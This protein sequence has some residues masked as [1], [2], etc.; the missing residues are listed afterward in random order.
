MLKITCQLSLFFV[1][2]LISTFKTFAQ[3]PGDHLLVDDKPLPEWVT[4]MYSENP[5]VTDVEKA[6]E[7]YYQIHPFEKN[8]YTQYFKRWR[9]WAIKYMDQDGYIKLKD[10]SEDLKTQDRLQALKGRSPESNWEFIGPKQTWSMGSSNQV[11]VTW[12]AN[13]YGL[14]IA[15]SNVN[16]VYAGMEGGG[17]YKSIDKGLNWTY[18]TPNLNIGSVRA[19]AVHPT[20][21]NTVYFGAGGFIYKSINGG[22]IWSVSLQSANLW[23]NDLLVNPANPS[24]IYAATN[25]GFK[26]SVN[27]GTSWSNILTGESWTVAIKPDNANI[28]YT[29]MDNGSSS[30]FYKSTD[31]G[32]VFIEKPTGWF[33]PGSGES[34]YGV[35]LTVSQANS[36]IIYALLGGDGT[37][38]NGYIG[39]YKSTNAGE[40]WTN[41]HGTL[42]T[43]YNINTH[44]NLMAHNG[45]DG[46]YQ[47]FYDF[48]IVA[49]PNNAEEVIVGGTSWWKSTNGG[50]LFAPLGSYVGGL[51]WSHPD[52]QWL[53]AQGNDLWICSDGGINYSTD[54]A[55]T[56][57]ARM[58]GISAS[59]FWGFDNGWNEDVLVGGRYHNGN[60]AYY[61]NY[62]EGQFLRMGGAEAATGYVNPG[63]NRRVY[64]SDIGGTIIPSTL[65]GDPEWF[66]VGK[67]PNE[68]YYAAEFSEMEWDPRCFNT[69]FIGNGNKIWKSSNGGIS[70][71]A[72]FTSPDA[73]SSIEHI[74]VSRKNS[75]V[76]YASQRSNDLWD[77]KIWKTTNGGNSWTACTTLPT[78]SGGGRRVMS[79]SADG[80]N[81]N[82]LYVG[83]AY[84]DANEK[85]YKT[86]DGGVSWIN[87]STPL[88]NNVTITDILHQIG[89]NGGIYIGTTNGV[90]YRNNVMSDWDY[91]SNNL[92]LTA[93]TCKLKPFYKKGKIRNATYGKSIWQCDLY[94]NAPPVA[95][96][97]VNKMTYDCPRDTFYFM[98]H[99]ALNETNA[100]WTWVFTG[101]SY[102]SSNT[103]K[104]PKVVYN[105]PGKYNVKLT[106]TDIYGT[107]TQTLKKLIV[108]NNLCG[109]DTIRGKCVQLYGNNNSSYVAVP[110][111][112]IN[113][114]AMTITA[115]VK[116]T[117]IQPEYSAVFMF[118]G[119][120]AAGFNFRESSNTL[121]YHWPNGAWWWDSNLTVPSGEWSHV[122]MVVE[123][124]GITLYVNGIGQKHNFSV[125]PIDFNQA[126]SYIGRYRDWGDRHMKGAV[127]ELCVW[128]KSL[129]QN[130]I[131]DLMHLT[132]V[133]ANDSFLKLYY[134]FNESNGP[135]LD[136]VGIAHGELAGSAAKINSTVPAGGGKS[137]RLNITSGGLKSFPGTEVNITFPA[138]GTYPNGDVIVYKING[139]PNTMPSTF[140]L[141]NSYWVIRNFGTNTNFTALSQLQFGNIGNVTNNQATMPANIKLY[142]RNTNSDIIWGTYI[143]SGDAV[144]TST[145]AQVTFNSGLNLTNFGQFEVAKEF[146]T[147]FQESEDHVLEPEVVDGFKPFTVYPT[148]LTTAAGVL[149][150]TNLLEEKSVLTILDANGNRLLYQE[151]FRELK[152]DLGHIP[153]G[154]YFY[155]VKNSQHLQT[156][157]LI[158]Q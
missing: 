24:I 56:I 48:A 71:S 138:S 55:G 35:R 78:S 147:L 45:T 110:R 89:T 86:M 145:N 152:T 95:Q 128:N 135:I 117:G 101:A 82:I 15:P 115:W 96:I 74:E 146:T 6:Y 5:K 29:V 27:G 72:V 39:V 143:E 121:G 127:D 64:H 13:T 73:T 2:M 94:E 79:I 31:Q 52:M 144:T 130:E 23:V 26:R 132:K 43:P 60:T 104:N 11:K 140:P 76:I 103:V 38:L 37:N 21:P 16:T 81:Q 59:D 84:G 22:V 91:F 113:T 12:Q 61:E 158:K 148:L 46:F 80:Q 41:P 49:N 118:N 108:V 116:P 40:S 151:F 125:S 14:A 139:T 92:P 83:L 112:N 65:N 33:V 47:G 87:L 77:G 93:Y 119:D 150:I 155:I 25:Q 99:S 90:Y 69:I 62:P 20:D 102:V 75:N 68:S 57:E 63:E 30:K 85:V 19:I 109:A 124:T 105:T 70:Y 141:S 131:R 4:L 114:N 8:T 142:K 58:N 149:N 44:P 54:F 129:T 32:A 50:V 10:P 153:A 134:Q 67:W 111:L 137:S 100:T 7:A 120:D 154:Q 133:P 156:G 53:E 88:L 28:I 122:A 136:K 18:I 66:D 157:K 34:V 1:L 3:T 42:G 106:V 9:Q 98:D 107:S 51:S 123:P 17:V 36:N 126:T 97:S